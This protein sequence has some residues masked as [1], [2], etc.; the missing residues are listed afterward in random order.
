MLPASQMSKPGWG[1]MDAIGVMDGVEVGNGIGVL[2]TASISMRVGRI[3]GDDTL[4]GCVCGTF[5]AE[6]HPVM[7][8]KTMPINSLPFILISLYLIQRQLCLFYS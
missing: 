7:T 4:T 3:V 2:V 8:I 1:V 6:A 5:D